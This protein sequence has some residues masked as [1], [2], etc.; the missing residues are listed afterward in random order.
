[1]PPSPS[2]R[3]STDKQDA[4]SIDDQL[5]RCREYA[6]RHQQEVVGEFTDAATSGAHTDHVNLRRMLDVATAT[7]RPPFKAV[8][9]DDLSRLSRDLGD[10]WRIIFTDLAAV[11]VRVIDASTWHGERRVGRAHHVRRDGD[12][13][14][15]VPSARAPRDASRPS[16]PGDRWGSAPAARCTA[17]RRS[18][19]RIRRTEITR[20][21]S[22]RS[23][24]RRRRSFGASTACSIKRHTG[25]AASRP[26]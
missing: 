5:R 19:R 15:H 12:G 22:G 3:Y 16:G 8:I 23:T 17:S 20:G 6:E 13:Q 26:C 14:R 2:T 9:V 11:D 10:T 1:M 18:R 25:T 24:K 21:S 4:R 7:K